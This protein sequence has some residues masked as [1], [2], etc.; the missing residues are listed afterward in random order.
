MPDYN[1][2]LDEMPGTPG[3]PQYDPHLTEKTKSFLDSLP[4][5]TGESTT[6]PNSGPIFQPGDINTSDLSRIN[7]DAEVTNSDLDNA[8]NSFKR[9]IDN[10]QIATIHGKLNY[11][12]GGTGALHNPFGDAPYEIVDNYGPA[13]AAL[14]QR[15]SLGDITQ[16]EF[17]AEMTSLNTAYSQAQELIASGKADI[18]S[19]ERE[20]E[21]EP[22][23]KGYEAMNQLVQQQGDQAG[24]FDK[25]KYSMP[26][27]MGS[28]AS[29]MLPQLAATFG[30]NISKAL[31]RSSV[32]Y[33]LGPEAGVP[34]N[35]IATIGATALSIGEILWGRHQESMGEIGSTIMEAQEKMMSDYMAEHNLTSKE[36]IPEDIQRDIRIA[37]RK[38]AD[39]QYKQNMALAS[40]DIVAALAMPMSN[41]G[42]GLG[43]LTRN[44][45]VISEALQSAVNY[46]KYT[47]V[48]G[49]LARMGITQYGEKFEEGFQYASQKRAEDA[50]YGKGQYVNSSALNAILDD[51][52]D[53]ISSLNYSLI[54]GI[55]MRGNGRYANDLEFQFSENS[56]GMLAALM[57]GIPGAIS[58][59]QD[60]RAYRAANKDLVQNGLVN[61]DGKISRIDNT[62]L[63]KYFDKDLISGRGIFTPKSETY[64]LISAV[65][66]LSKQKDENG[67]PLV[68][69]TKINGMIADIESKYDRYS[70]IAD[71]V[72]NRIPSD[73][74]IGPSKEFKL[75]RQT[76]KL[77]AFNAVMEIDKRSQMQGELQGVAQGLAQ[78]ENALFSDPKYAQHYAANAQLNAFKSIKAE[79]EA[80]KDTVKNYDAHLEIIDKNIKESEELLTQLEKPKDVVE[81]SAKLVDAIKDYASNQLFLGDAKAQYAELSRI[82]SRSDMF[83]YYNKNKTR[84]TEPVLDEEFTEAE[85]VSSTPTPSTTPNPNPQPVLNAQ[86]APTQTPTSTAPSTP[87][88][89]QDKQKDANPIVATEQTK[90]DL[91]SQISRASDTSL[92]M[93]DRIKALQEFLTYANINPQDPEDDFGAHTIAQ[94]FFQN[95]NNLD[96]VADN[97]DAIQEVVR[98]IDPKAPQFTSTVGINPDGSKSLSW[99]Y[100]DPNATP[101]VTVDENTPEE[102]KQDLLN[103]NVDNGIPPIQDKKFVND[104]NVVTSYAEYPNTDIG[105]KI[106]SGLSLAGR[107]VEGQMG[108]DRRWR[109]GYNNDQLVFSSQHEQQLVNTSA[110]SIKDKLTLRAEF[111]DGFDTSNE[112]DEN[113][114]AVDI[115]VYKNVEVSKGIFQPLKINYLHRLQKLPDLLADSAVLSV[116]LEILRN[117]RRT[118][119]R[120]G[121]GAEFTMEVVD[122]GFGFLNTNN[123]TSTVANA[124]GDD[125]RPTITV[126]Q[127]NGRPYETGRIMLTPAKGMKKGATVLLVPNETPFGTMYVPLYLRKEK[128][129]KDPAIHQKVSDSVVAY[130]NHNTN[131][132]TL[133]DPAKKYVYILNRN[134]DLMSLGKAG[135][136]R[137]LDSKTPKVFIN[138]TEYSTDKNNVDQVPQALENIYFSANVE[139]LEDEAYMKEIMNSPLLQTDITPNT[140]IVDKV[141][142]GQYSFLPKDQKYSYFSQHTVVLG[143]LAK[144]STLIDTTPTDEITDIDAI[145]STP[146][147]E[148]RIADIN[149]RREEAIHQAVLDSSDYKGYLNSLEEAKADTS[150]FRDDMVA[151]AEQKLRTMYDDL[152]NK[153]IKV[154]DINAQYDAEIAALSGDTTQISGYG[155][156]A[157]DY[158]FSGVG[159]MLSTDYLMQALS[160]TFL[161]AGAQIESIRQKYIG[162][163]GNL[164]NISDVVDTPD[165]TAMM[166]EVRQ[167]VEDTYR[168]DEMVS[169]FDKIMEYPTGMPNKLGNEISGKIEAIESSMENAPVSEGETTITKEE[170]DQANQIDFSAFNDEQD[171]M[172][173]VFEDPGQRASKELLIDPEMGNTL[174]NEIVSSVAY[175]LLNN[176]KEE[177][178][179]EKI[180]NADKVR[181]NLQTIYDK[182]APVYKLAKAAYDAQGQAYLDANP[183]ADKFLKKN[184]PLVRAYDLMFKNWNEVVLRAKTMLKDVGQRELSDE[185]DY[186][187]NFDETDNEEDNNVTQFNDDSNRTRNEKD[188]LPK[189][190]KRLLMFIPEVE[191]LDQVNEKTGKDYRT[192]ANSLNLPRFNDFTDSWNKIQSVT[193]KHFF[194]STRSGFIEMLKVLS[195][196]TN[197]PVV[198]MFAEKLAKAPTQVQNS[199]F[200]RL[201]LYNM[202]NEILISRQNVV[203][204]SF[205]DGS[206]PNTWKLTTTR[207]VAADRRQG[208]KSTI[209]T[210]TAE[211]FQANKTTG[212]FVTQTNDHGIE[213]YF[214]NSPLAKT[215]HDQVYQLINDDASFE[216]YQRT[217]KATSTFKMEVRDQIYDIVKN[218]LGL[219]IHRGAFNKILQREG[220]NKV[221]GRPDHKVAVD[222]TFQFILSSFSNPGKNNTYKPIGTLEGVGLFENESAAINVVA[223][224]EYEYRTDRV[225]GSYNIDGKSYYPFVRPNYLTEI[226]SMLESKKNG[227]PSYFID[228]RVN[229]DSYAK[230]GRTLRAFSDPNQHKLA[231]SIALTAELGSRNDA[232]NGDTKLMKDMTPR[233]HK[234]TKLKSFQNAGK[235]MAKYYFDTLSDKTWKPKPQEYRIDI[236]YNNAN[237][238]IDGNSIV[239]SSQNLEEMYR[240]FQGE[241]DRIKDVITQNNTLPAHLKIKGYHDR[242]KSEGMGKYFVSLYFMNK[243]VLD[244]DNPSLSKA[245]YNENGTLKDITPELKNQIKAEFNRQLN[246][247]YRD[248]KSDFEAN[249]MWQITQ[250]EDPTQPGVFYPH[251]EIGDFLDHYYL[252]NGLRGDSNAKNRGVLAK[253]GL[254]DHPGKDRIVRFGDYDLIAIEDMNRAIDFAVIDYAFNYAMSTLDKYTLTGDPAQ[255]GKPAKLSDAVKE[256]YANDPLGLAKAALLFN[257]ESTFVNLGKRNASFAASG[258]SA[259]WSSDTYNVA[260]AKDMPILSPQFEQ[261][262]S[263]F[264]DNEGGIKKGYNDGDLT[265]AQEITTVE[266][267]L[268]QQL[269]YGSISEDKFMKALW[270]YDRE[271]YKERFPDKTE[272]I[273]SKDRADAAMVI[274]Q[275][276]K[277]VQRIGMYDNEMQM[278][279]QY[280][281]KTSSFPLVPSLVTGALADLLKDMKK[282]KVQ[283]IPFAS[284]IKQGLHGEKD[285]FNEDG[286]YNTSFFKD[287]VVNLHRNAFRIQLEVPYKTYKEEVREATQKSKLL[288]V[289]LPQD[290]K[291]MIGSEEKSVKELTQEYTDVHK[292]I[293]DTKKNELFKELGAKVDENGKITLSKSFFKKLSEMLIREGQGRG[294][295]LN[296]LLGLTLNEQGE[297]LIP[298]TFLPNAGQIEPVLTSIVSNRL[299]RLKMSGKSYVQASEFVLRTGKVYSDINDV[300]DPR[301]IIWT[302]PSYAGTQKLQYIRVEDAEG[303]LYKGSLDEIPEG[304]EIKPAQ[305]VMPMYFIDPRI[306]HDGHAARVDHADYMVQ[307]DGKTYLDTSKIDPELLQ[308][309]GFRIPFQGHNSAMWFE[310]VGFLPEHYGDMIIVPGE[311]AAEMGSDYDVDKLYGYLYNYYF[312]EMNNIR[313]IKDSDTQTGKEYA[314]GMVKN[315]LDLLSEADLTIKKN[316][317]RMMD[318]EKAVLMSVHT[319]PAI[320]DPLSFQDMEDVIDHFGAQDTSSFMGAYSPRYQDDVYFSNSTGKFGVGVSANNNTN[321][322]L[323]QTTNLFTIVEGMKFLDEQGNPL[324]DTIYDDNGTRLADPENAVSKDVKYEYD[325]MEETVD[326]VA[327]NAAQDS[328]WRLDKIYTFPDPVTGK[329]YRISNLISQVLGVSVDNAKEQKLGGFGINRQNMNTAVTM[330]RHGLSFGWVYAFINQPILKEYYKA[331]GGTSDIYDVNFTPNKREQVV[332]DIFSKYQTMFNIH[333]N[334]QELEGIRAF[335][336]AE[337]DQSLDIRNGNKGINASNARQQ[338]EILKAFLHY[339][340]IA[341]ALQS[342]ASTVNLDTKGNP[343]NMITTLDKIDQVSNLA[344]NSVLGNLDRYLSE[345]IPGL[346]TDVPQITSDLFMNKDQSLYA[347]GSEA[348]RAIRSDVKYHLGKTA[349]YEADLDLINREAKQFFYSGFRLSGDNRTAEEIRDELVYGDNSLQDRLYRLKERY[350]ENDFVDSLRAIPSLN[351]SDPKLVRIEMSSDDDFVSRISELWD[352]AL[353]DKNDPE[354]AQ[355]ARDLV[356][357]SLFMS[358]KEYGRT[359][360]IRYIPPMYL[361]QI[362]F[363]SYLSDINRRMN[364]IDGQVSGE[365]MITQFA[366]QFAQHNKDFLVV[367][368][369]GRSKSSQAIKGS[370]SYRKGMKDGR[371]IDVVLNEFS[372][373]S[374][375]SEEAKE[376][377]NIRS[378]MRVDPEGRKYYPTFVSVFIDE[379][380]GKQVFEG[381]KNPNGSYTYYRIDTLGSNDAAEYDMYNESD[382]LFGGTS[383][384][385]VSV[386]RSNAV[387]SVVRPEGVSQIGD[388]PQD[389]KPYM[390]QTNGDNML[391]GIVDRLGKMYDSLPKAMDQQMATLYQFVAKHIMYKGLDKV[392]IDINPNLTAAGTTNPSGDQIVVTF[393]P[394]LMDE[395]RTGLDSELERIRTI[396]H[397]FVHALTFQNIKAGRNKE[398]FEKIKQVWDAFRKNTVNTSDTVR[399]VPKGAFEAELF[400]QLKEMYDAAKRENQD[401]ASTHLFD[402][403]DQK[404]SNHAETI[405]ILSKVGK[406]LEK[407]AIEGTIKDGNYDLTSNMDRANDFVS[408][409]QGEFIDEILENT[410]KYYA[411]VNV[412]EFM[413]EAM[414]NLDVVDALSDMPSLWKQFVNSVKAIIN[415]IFGVDTD[416]RDLFDDAIDSIFDYLKTDKTPTNMRPSVLQMQPDNIEKIKNGT[417]R[418]TNRTSRIEDGVYDLPDGTKVDV[419]YIGEYKVV[420]NMLIN[421]AT[422]QSFNKDSFARAEGFESWDDFAANNKYSSNF[423]NGSQS[424]FVYSV[425]T[426]SK[427]LEDPSTLKSK[428]G[429]KKGKC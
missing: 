98:M 222:N 101:T 301:D 54:P 253:L 402:Y 225:S 62:I 161:T 36:Q 117:V 284:G 110:I 326:R 129:S 81:P 279:K 11:G 157:S 378:L 208:V 404:L 300:K 132:S 94:S 82:S 350:E 416:E 359:N 408:Y 377:L 252:T 135:I 382:T 429:F 12:S 60:I 399:G 148:S 360:L 48:L 274:F 395:G 10:I 412:Y 270:I 403:I 420:Q 99:D 195:D 282:N 306:D 102:D 74:L 379:D 76:V 51:S 183:G 75:A 91:T 87:S 285:M 355:F 346:F 197:Y 361:K 44:T 106:T 299:T 52:Y 407:L 194:D 214:I 234:L 156:I 415:K 162:M 47:R 34:A 151:N 292:N 276:K 305:I 297:F 84:M 56:G 266:E 97:F 413:S 389:V 31:L 49:T 78:S 165:Y 130:L 278:T 394:T 71:R 398:E 154:A 22:V 244:V 57:G 20:I 246:I 92:P 368:R 210:L 337:L 229:G 175:Q 380:F 304:F 188:Y 223:Y 421:T 376:N 184:G 418:V 336:F 316:Q 191:M 310:I 256:K 327:E 363:T 164:G 131:K 251:Y 211:M 69:P 103:Q 240:Y 362:G 26:N 16:A 169:L 189:D 113:Y 50:I 386:P 290:L 247:M 322:A 344:K 73:G 324:S 86:G 150:P 242:G 186:Y 348:Y 345:T 126:V 67:N 146:S 79:H 231:K 70:E 61:I 358:P 303:N 18:A 64:H 216:V 236:E 176:T 46:N 343:K 174:Q 138:G 170:L 335:S 217:G 43:A 139:A 89:T 203:V 374:P 205:P 128:L 287:N 41:F 265:D 149:T 182:F 196:N 233:E 127:K 105:F 215:L 136:F 364:N 426:H 166:S 237:G 42:S 411:Y 206:R 7:I 384:S 291:M 172:N 187:E 118:I 53:T 334:V 397:E 332:A 21:N 200:G 405:S 295:A 230:Y 353:K 272:T 95:T 367:A 178:D 366:R 121:Q 365:G 313:L 314:E 281:I 141:N 311:I 406:R 323:A 77:D 410:N 59:G 388:T 271:A 227:G 155:G 307:K 177:G 280:Y 100:I 213:Q 145:F 152:R 37:S 219:N 32:T 264:P 255:A 400:S 9:G 163:I 212:M 120:E 228:D 218:K 387:A 396:L 232:G 330:I 15:L 392:R 190:V 72:D 24:F 302:N 159:A 277:P 28:S 160:G 142:K 317:N 235:R 104:E 226:Y 351:P 134:E 428:L 33:A 19:N 25:M 373:V 27:I 45:K 349:L 393:N 312:D 116:E 66:S 261:Y 259:P 65:R 401:V 296:A 39:I 422:N 419:R 93:I 181:A 168:N 250:N 185:D 390:E 58:V 249:D 158:L 204:E 267:D 309:N 318:I 275:P 352:A 68:D 107:N 144:G 383:R 254:D 4:T 357:Y 23:N 220:A 29:L 143:N 30:N 354:F 308:F 369:A 40:Q 370:E 258:V 173:D 381:V 319:L 224:A 263:F 80:N 315:S 35:V 133:L 90:N 268:E 238:S 239:M 427:N 13:K 328:A 340:G 269:T 202:P 88:P 338:L 289:D 207:T 341:E 2:R 298:L 424:R 241:Y 55:D 167:A 329:R 201:R 391:E 245:L 17:D 180:S 8:W 331:L 109:D 85:V 114:D 385:D 339:K 123:V 1:N 356:M 119:I 243:A 124:I 375:E 283:R 115:A 262:K 293:L 371:V 193:T 5:L 125:T 112:S 288:F 111:P 325:T 192:V 171:D 372:V 273:T 342:V 221:T 333:D 294:Y 6:N 14:E 198:R 414:T 209:E 122:K 3:V 321:H 108:A 153:L 248:I 63:A 409:A 257:I 417:K 38:G 199:A 423:V 347:Y 137:P 425:K 260:M 179:I 96:L 83:K 147:L 140:Q 286:S 320:I